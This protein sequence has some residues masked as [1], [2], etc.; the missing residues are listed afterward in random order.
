[1]NAHR[2]PCLGLLLLA[3]VLP[4]AGCGGGS[5][6]SPSKTRDIHGMVL[7]GTKA[8]FRNPTG[9]D[10][11]V[12]VGKGV[13]VR[14]VYIDRDSTFNTADSPTTD[15]QGRFV[16]KIPEPES[17]GYFADSADTCST[18]VEFGVDP[19]TGQVVTQYDAAYF[20]NHKPS[21]FMADKAVVAAKALGVDMV[22]LVGADADS[23]SQ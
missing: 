19:S 4:V 1:M 6:T 8:A 14:I 22:V 15:A 20:A 11:L 9:A 23:C 2:L 7:M 16:F 12:P 17:A 21:T 3:A 18:V 10:G 13:P 5:G